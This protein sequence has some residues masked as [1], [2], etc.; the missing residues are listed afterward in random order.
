M[1]L[2]F[3]LT[4]VFLGF[5]CSSAAGQ[6][7]VPPQPGNQLSITASVTV[8]FD[9]STGLYT[10][11]Y[12]FANAA[13]SAQEAW[14]VVLE[15]SGDAAQTVTN[16]QTPQGWHFM[17]HPSDSMVSWA[18][19]DVGTVPANFVDDGSILPSPY[20]IK[21]GQTLGGF[22]FQSLRPPMAIKFYA[23]GFTQIPQAVDAGDLFEAGYLMKD[24]TDNSIIGVT[25]G[26]TPTDPSTQPSGLGFFNFLQITNGAVRKSPVSVGVHFNQSVG[27]IDVTSFH[28]SLNGKDI[29][30]A[31]SP[32]GTGSDLAAAL[33][34]SSSP[35]VDDKNVLEGVVSGIPTGRTDSRYDLNHVRFYV[36]SPRSLDLNGDGKIDCGDLA[37]VTA[38]LGKKVGDA[39]F[40][41][42]ADVNGDGVVDSLDVNILQPFCNGQ[43]GTLSATATTL[44]GSPNPATLGQAVTF[45]AMVVPTPA[46][47]VSLTGVVALFDGTTKI[48][49][50][51]LDNTRKAT[52]PTSA[53][54][55]GSHS[56]T[57]QYG[58]DANFTASTS[59]ALT[60]SVVPP[61]AT[62]TALASSLN[63][64]T[65]GASVTFT[66][67]VTSSG[68]GTPTG[69]VTFL[70][71]ATRLSTAAINTQGQAA[72][73]TAALLQGAHSITAQY[74]GDANFSGNTSGVLTET[75]NAAQAPDFT[76][77]INP[78]SVS[79][80]SPGAISSP[81]TLTITGQNGYSGQVQFTQQTSC[82]ISPAGSKSACI[83]KPELVSGSGS[84]QVTITTYPDTHTGRVPANRPG[85]HY[86]WIPTSFAAMLALIS[87]FAVPIGRY[88]W[89][90]AFGFALLTLLAV[91]I[92]CGIA[93]DS[94]GTTNP[95]TPRGITYTVIV[96][97]TGN[98]GQPSHTTIFTFIVH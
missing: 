2:R 38:S 86:W 44:G 95:G 66:A 87:L 11:S 6:V 59:T 33:D 28:A 10:Y 13:S 23:Q 53:L 73:S 47:N 26:P 27:T 40:D 42:R 49:M 25:Q 74:G 29:T 17:R 30:A 65:T 64:A 54:I 20:Q 51:A 88:R 18:A 97:A 36:N 55:L 71:G 12:S 9:S 67:T 79:V 7:I 3:L 76:L 19:T 41:P 60:Q 94:G 46:T 43:G 69:T 84:T 91:C 35:L 1:A 21:P 32:T 14:F 62:T 80:T 24:F 98:G 48:G 16:P 81:T 58:G 78:A 61:S 90:A 63:P 45:I 68:S 93:G 96:T 92:G 39:G 89:S 82:S 4:V 8:T 72:L 70:D 34:K 22:S 5:C 85:G 75:V 15:L 37:I 52:L 57:A 50:S 83:F 77:S 56:I 31:F